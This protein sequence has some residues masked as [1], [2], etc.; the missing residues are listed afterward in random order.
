MA[1]GQ[2]WH[3]GLLITK[4]L[5]ALGHFYSVLLYRMILY[6]TFLS[7][8]V[9][10]SWFPSVGGLRESLEVEEGDADKNDLN[11]YVL[12]AS[13]DCKSKSATCFYT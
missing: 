11:T 6:H 1:Y 4:P 12:V 9:T 13:S 10:R 3:L 5:K 2:S 8:V 7:L